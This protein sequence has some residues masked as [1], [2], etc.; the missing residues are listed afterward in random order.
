M[1]FVFN[2]PKFLWL[3]DF[4]MFSGYLQPYER[5][6]SICIYIYIKLVLICS[7]KDQCIIYHY[8]TVYLFLIQSES[9]VTEDSFPNIF[10]LSSR[11]KTY[12]KGK[13]S[14]KIH[15]FLS[16]ETVQPHKRQVSWYQASSCCQPHVNNITQQDQGVMASVMR[17]DHDL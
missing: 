5:Q 12:F 16:K 9:R 13:Q 4:Q 6:N 15:R 1:D 14:W 7:K 3:P 11:N 8:H 10:E 17:K 2:S